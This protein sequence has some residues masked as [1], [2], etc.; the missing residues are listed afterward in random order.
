MSC[1]EV[2][3]IFKPPCIDLVQEICTSDHNA[4]LA[5]P[6][7][8]ISLAGTSEDVAVDYTWLT[9]ICS[10]LSFRKTLRHLIQ[11]G[12]EKEPLGV[13]EN[14]ERL[15]FG[16]ELGGLEGSS[17]ELIV[18]QNTFEVHLKDR[19]NLQDAVLDIIQA[20]IG[21]LEELSP[22]ILCTLLPP[23]H[24]GAASSE[25][26]S[27][28]NLEPVVVDEVNDELLELLPWNVRKLVKHVST[29]FI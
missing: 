23:S 4:N 14:Q 17:D 25:K 11:C 15:F 19:A 29:P 3:S 16:R 6:D 7:I 5:S 24:V 12:V 9:H 26:E 28:D 20:R 8:A 22:Q 13:P 10:H 27:A 1:L 21:A 2:R 18:E